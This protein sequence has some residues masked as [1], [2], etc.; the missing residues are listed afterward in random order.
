MVQQLRQHLKF[1]ERYFCHFCSWVGASHVTDAA[2]ML[3]PPPPRYA[4]VFCHRCLKYVP[5]YVALLIFT[6]LL[7]LL[8]GPNDRLTYLGVYIYIKLHKYQRTTTEYQKDTQ[9]NK[10]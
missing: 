7:T 6:T 4:N 5:M 9:K 2:T 1:Q 3:R 10:T 8:L